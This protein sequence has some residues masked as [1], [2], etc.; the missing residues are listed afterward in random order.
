MGVPM[1]L[2][3]EDNAA[4][5]GEGDQTSGYTLITTAHRVKHKES[6]Q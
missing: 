6:G 4:L 5:G 3:V 1:I 2:M